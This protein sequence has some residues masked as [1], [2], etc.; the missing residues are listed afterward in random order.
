MSFSVLN[1][2]GVISG[3]HKTLLKKERRGGRRGVEKKGK[4]EREPEVAAHTCNPSTRRLRLEE[5]QFKAR[6]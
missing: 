6:L 5:L 1:E 4:K 2:L 3:L